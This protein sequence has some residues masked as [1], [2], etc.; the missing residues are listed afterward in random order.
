MSKKVFISYS[1]KDESY[2]KD[3]E[4]HLSML[5]RKEIISVWHD[6]KITP[7]E[8]WRNSI[9]TNLEEAELIIFLVSSSFLASDYCFDV[10]VKKAIQKQAEGSS[11]IISII[12]RPCDWVDCEFAKFQAVPQNAKPITLW[13]NQ[14]TAWLD[15]IDGIKKTL[16]TFTFV[17]NEVMHLNKVEITP[18][19][20][21]WLDDTEIVLTHRRV[22]KV[23]L[24]EIYVTP[25]IEIE[26]ER[27]DIINIENSQQ[28][29]S[30]PNFYLISGEEQQGKTSLLKYLFR[31]F[32]KKSYL[33][34]YI[35]ASDVKKSD[36]SKTLENAIT[37]QYI[38]LTT[39]Q[40]ISYEDSIIFIDNIDN[41]KLNNKHTEKFIKQVQETFKHVVLTCH[42][43]FDLVSSEITYL[44][45]YLVCRLLGLGNLKREE[46]AKK[47]IALGVE[48]SIEEKELYSECDE[49]KARLNTAIKK[50]IV[51]PK[52]VYVLMLIQM[53]EA[54]AKQSIELTSYGHC[55]QQLIYQS[56]E[57]AKV[58][59]TEYD[60]YFN[61]LTELSWEIF[62]LKSGLNQHQLD[63]F[64]A[65]YSQMYLA[66]NQKEIIDNLVGCR[67]LEWKDNKLKFKYPYIYYFFVGKKIAEY[68][69]SQDNVSS[70]VDYL[71]ENLHREDFANILIF[72]THH[73]KDSW[74]LSKIRTVLE[75]IFQENEQAS[76]N[77]NQ[78]QFMEE[79]IKEIPELVI[80]QREIQ[81]ERDKHNKRLDEIDSIED[82]DENEPLDILATINKAFKGMD[83]AGQII[84]N[85][86]ASM[87]RQ[88]LY[89]LAE[90]GIST[91]LRFLDYF[92][93]ISD[94]AKA[95]IINFI[96]ERIEDHPSSSDTQIKKRA[97]NIY[98]HMTYG[99]INVIVR[100]IAIS[101]GSRDAREI[102][103]QLESDKQTPAYVL[104][105]QAIEL[106]YTRTLKIS[107]IEKT[108][109]KVKDNPIC[110][111]ILKEMVI[112]HIY[113]FPVGYKEKQ[114]L[115]DLLNLS[116]KGQRLMDQRKLAKG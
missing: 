66:V 114:Q 90:S 99:V 16:E 27:S 72:I 87:T 46:I 69:A 103:N 110:L 15:V 29:L 52:P 58:K 111:R 83:V 77:K 88:M 1:H 6:R 53:F 62:D 108:L 3:L 85:R 57:Q 106:Q 22:D 84:R 41:I 68:Y 49:L 2:R 102:Y 94:T 78:V 48:E 38:N 34:L 67:I 70:E 104:V 50:N 54:Y 14:D 75:S 63:V 20:N 37:Q 92:I 40:L 4:D 8:E 98:L 26:D 35:D 79:F 95:E 10:E 44:D 86:H 28:I 73:T 101:I 47:W 18:E 55:Y 113:M 43:S 42:S 91:G 82:S 33:P 17:K 45:S 11:K 61:V 30:E 59:N 23:K 96:K 36:L 89:E 116:I 7:S 19:T 74:L 39:E 56:L 5:K 13:D 60:R 93:R 65:D 12:V 9:D 81:F 80:E 107:S 31:E 105:N 115:S 32:S 100:K 64:F 25:D 21:S 24:S 71:L 76:L 97:E 112:Q 51:P 109:E